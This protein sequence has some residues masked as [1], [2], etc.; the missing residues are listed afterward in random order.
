MVADDGLDG[1][2]VCIY[3]EKEDSRG[4]KKCCVCVKDYGQGGKI[5]KGV[6]IL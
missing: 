3:I 6:I 2:Y 4:W 1:M 5:N